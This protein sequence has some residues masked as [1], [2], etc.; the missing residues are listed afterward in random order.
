MVARGPGPRWSRVVLVALAG[1][2]YACLLRHPSDR[3]QPLAYFSECTRLF[4]E[5]DHVALEYRLEA[6]SCG[7]RKWVPLDPRPYFPIEA[8]DKESRFQRFGYFYAERGPAEE[9][10]TVLGALD[11]Y[12]VDR[13]TGVDDGVADAIG[14]IRM[15]KWTR[16]LPSPGD[17]VDRYVFRPFA[18]VPADERTNL[19][20][21]RAS[22]RKQRCGTAPP[23]SEE[24]EP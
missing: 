17:P 19:F 8:D 21:T 14:G 24:P 20:N 1:I 3:W 11:A 9:R 18:P 23:I 15:Y 13:H 2:Y 12:V 5:A 16:S 6:W 4:P 7:E 10:R 22:L